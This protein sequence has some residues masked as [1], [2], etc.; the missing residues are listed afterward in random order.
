VIPL[1]SEYSSVSE[2]TLMKDLH[3]LLLFLGDIPYFTSIK[4]YRENHS[5]IDPNLCIG[6][7]V[8]ILPDIAQLNPCSRENTSTRVIVGGNEI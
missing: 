5:F 7:N 8:A 4:Q 3:A 2:A 1:Y 6:L